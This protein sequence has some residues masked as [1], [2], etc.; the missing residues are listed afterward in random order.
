MTRD[1]CKPSFCRP[2]GALI[3]FMARKPWAGAHGY[4]LP[5]L[6]GCWSSNPEPWAGAL[7]YMLSPLRGC[8][9]SNPEPWAGALGYMLPP[10]RGCRASNPEPW[11][12]ARLRVSPLRGFD[13][14][15]AL[16]PVGLRAVC[17]LPPLRGHVLVF[18]F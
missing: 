4:M 2:C 13:V 14:R 17:T 11:A 7:G 12:G 9:A 15:A 3:I 6:R 5:P 10:L 18:R 8:R 16:I 1:I